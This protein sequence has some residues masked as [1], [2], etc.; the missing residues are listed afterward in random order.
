MESNLIFIFY[1]NMNIS[2]IFI[3]N[4]FLGKL[5]IKKFVLRARLL[6]LN[7]NEQE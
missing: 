1:L 4:I 3:E 6:Q 5:F 7:V 2:L